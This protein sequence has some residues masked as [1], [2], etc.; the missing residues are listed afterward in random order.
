MGMKIELYNTMSGKKEEFVPLKKG[1]VTMYNCGPTVYDRA[2][3]GNLRSYVFADT[4]RRALEYTGLTVTQ[5]INVTDVGHLSGENAGDADSGE[6]KMSKA[7]ARENMPFTLAAMKELGTKYFDLFVEDLKELHVELPSAFPRASEHIVEDIELIR[8]LEK[9][10]FVYPIKDGVYFD[11]KKF[12][13][14]GKLGKIRLHSKIK[15]LMDESRITANPEKKHPADFA[16]WKLNRI[17]DGTSDTINTGWDS[18]W[19]KGFP[20][21]HIECSAMS[22]KYLGQPFDIHTGGIDHIPVHHNNEI[23]QSE[24]AYGVP[25]ANYWMHNAFVTLRES[26]MAKSKGSFIT[27]GSLQD[28]SVSP[29][30]YRYWLLTAHYRSPVNFTYQAVRAAQNG[31]VRFMAAISGYPEGGTIIPSYKKSFEAFIED[32]LDTPQAIALSWKLINDTEQSP[33]DKRSTLLDFDRIFGLDLGVVPKFRD[34]TEEDIPADVRALTDARKEARTR[35][36][37]GK[38]DAFR[39]EIEKRGFDVLDT[40]KGSRIIKK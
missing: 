24:A 18:P 34:I 26:K 1:M 37:W 31:L 5:V 40:D 17:S 36:D 13:G 11:T 2:H 38:A 22:R 20:G 16:V 35:K 23:A 21:W 27:L 39:I 6:D 32:D 28:D 25:L 9:K 30:A 8:E 19:G 3:I 14:Y 7:L 10:G 15:S 4:L 29:L 33:A 12:K